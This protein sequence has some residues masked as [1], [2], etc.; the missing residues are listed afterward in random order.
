MRDGFSHEL[1][2]EM[3]KILN[4]ECSMNLFNFLNKVKPLLDGVFTLSST[5]STFQISLVKQ[6][7]MLL[8][9]FC[10]CSC[11]KTGFVIP[12]SSTV[13]KR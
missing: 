13:T 7:D 6:T 1:I 12:S 11:A 10:I 3:E 2:V 8:Y 9:I 5:C 4:S